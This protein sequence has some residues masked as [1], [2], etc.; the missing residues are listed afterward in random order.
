MDERKDLSD[1]DIKELLEEIMRMR[2]ENDSVVDKRVD[3]DNALGC[4]I[5]EFLS[6]FIL[7]GYDMQGD[8]VVIRSEENQMGR[9]AL[10][11]FVLKYLQMMLYEE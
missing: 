11:S 9:D 4:T 6:S 2:V 5:K 8:P 7:I 10:R 1:N 3:I